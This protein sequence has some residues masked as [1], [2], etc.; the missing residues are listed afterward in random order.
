MTRAELRAEQAD[1]VA[2]LKDAPDEYHPDARVAAAF[3]DLKANAA[4]LTWL[5]S[6]IKRLDAKIAEHPLNESQLLTR[7]GVTKLL[8]DSV[9]AERVELEEVAAQWLPQPAK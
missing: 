8:L 1:M 3:A 4:T 9:K 7:R 2:R 5:E 6:E